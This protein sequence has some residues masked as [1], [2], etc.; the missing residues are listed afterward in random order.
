MWTG[1][2]ITDIGINAAIKR[3]GMSY[4]GQVIGIVPRSMRALDR[5]YVHPE[6]FLANSI[7][8]LSSLETITLVN[9]THRLSDK[10]DRSSG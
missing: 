5:D 10:R 8:G 4:A 1:D 3:F 7:S 2:G 6:N 9:G